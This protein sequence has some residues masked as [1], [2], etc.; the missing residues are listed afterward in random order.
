VAYT[1]IEGREQLLD[2]LAEAADQIGVALASLGAAYEKVDDMTADRLEENLFGP[3]QRAYGVAKRTHSEFAA[4]HDLSGRS[5]EQ[6]AVP[7][8]SLSARELID[9]A[10]EA[11]GQADNS[12]A[13]LQD[14][15]ALIEVGDV[16]LRSGLAAVREAV[17][18]VPLQTRAI[19]RT[20]GR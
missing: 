14:D 9:A 6:P 7:P 16:E 15:R 18:V 13:E 10:D 17:G 19:L 4:R 3:V 11:A 8:A 1:N 12:L 20:L 5:F 2:A